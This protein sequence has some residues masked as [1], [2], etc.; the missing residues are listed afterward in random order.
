MA[1]IVI[2]LPGFPLRS[3]NAIVLNFLS[4]SLSFSRGQSAAEKPINACGVTW[5]TRQAKTLLFIMACLE[6]RSR[7]W[8][9]MAQMV[10]RENHLEN[11]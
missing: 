1:Q 10:V 4:L 3:S 6:A 9:N 8:L 2:W 7:N 5:S 11:L